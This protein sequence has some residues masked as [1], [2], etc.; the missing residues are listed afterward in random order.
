[1]AGGKYATQ[2][3]VSSDATKI[4]IERTL[5]RYGA[6]QFMSGWQNNS[7]IVGFRINER[8]FRIS[9][10][11]PD[12]DSDELNFREVRTPTGQVGRTERSRK[13]RDNLYEQLVRTRWR[14]LLLVL[15]ATLEAVDVGIFTLEEALVAHTLLANNQTVAEWVEPQ[16]AQVYKSGEMPENL[17]GLP[18]PRAQAKRLALSR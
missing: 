11:L 2:T 8:M 9:V 17:P 5:R 14:A 18:A 1:M 12:P 6:D 7:A 13:T 15:K 3:Q 4:E 10:P 16:I